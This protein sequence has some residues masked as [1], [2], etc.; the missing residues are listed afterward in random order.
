MK[1]LC[2]SDRTTDF[3]EGC[4]RKSSLS[5][6]AL[7]LTS[8]YDLVMYFAPEKEFTEYFKEQIFKKK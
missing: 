6:S 7:N 5:T 8:G 3:K 1:L 4:Q 2:N